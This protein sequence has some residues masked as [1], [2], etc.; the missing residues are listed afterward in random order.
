M[1][2]T[3]TSRPA[4]L[5]IGANIEYGSAFSRETGIVTEIGELSQNIQV[6][7]VRRP[8]GRVIPLYFRANQR[9]RFAPTGDLGMN[10]N[11]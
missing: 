8:H 7:H 1:P 9:V 4:A 2:N 5:P 3:K 11:L 10:P 6:V